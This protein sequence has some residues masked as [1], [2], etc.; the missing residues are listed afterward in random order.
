MKLKCMSM[1]NLIKKS[2]AAITQLPNHFIDMEIIETLLKQ[3]K[4][5]LKQTRKGAENFIIY[6][7]RCANFNKP[8]SR[9]FAN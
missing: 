9:N 8:V 5:K 3:P 1:K 7:N 2:T 6:I 4:T